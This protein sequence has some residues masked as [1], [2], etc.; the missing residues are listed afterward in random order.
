MKRGSARSLELKNVSDII[1]CNAFPSKIYCNMPKYNTYHHHQVPVETV[2]ES[3][4]YLTTRET[5]KVDLCYY[6]GNV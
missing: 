5:T 1:G 3:S 2:Y 6:C 4:I